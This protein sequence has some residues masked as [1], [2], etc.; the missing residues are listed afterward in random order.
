[1]TSAR[2]LNRGR[3]STLARRWSPPTKRA[4]KRSRSDGSLYRDDMLLEIGRCESTP[5]CRAVVALSIVAEVNP[6]HLPNMEG[7]DGEGT[8]NRN[9]SDDFPV[10]LTISLEMLEGV[11]HGT[12]GIYSCVSGRS[13]QFPA[14]DQ[15]AVFWRPV[16]N[17]ASPATVCSS[18]RFLQQLSRGVGSGR[19][20]WM[21]IADGSP[22]PNLVS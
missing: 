11:E 2:L 22:V 18:S 8:P 13:R 17:L 14:T 12:W 15:A 4:V 1:M 3:L 20:S 10:T 5:C 6:P 7:P 21:S 16:Q 9:R 19:L